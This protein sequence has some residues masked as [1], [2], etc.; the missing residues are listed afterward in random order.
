LDEFIK[1]KHRE[2]QQAG[3]ANGADTGAGEEKQGGSKDQ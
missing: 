1:E 3:T 2:E